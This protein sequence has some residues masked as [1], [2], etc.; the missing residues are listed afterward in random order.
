MFDE[1]FAVLT[2]LFVATLLLMSP[3][4]RAVAATFWATSFRAATID[5]T[6]DDTALGVWLM[7][8]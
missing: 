5:A 7:P 6:M 3:V 8:M 1:D 4:P 2:A